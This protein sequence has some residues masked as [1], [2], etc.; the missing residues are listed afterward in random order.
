MTS[1]SSNSKQSVNIIK[2]I[3]HTR[4]YLM[5][6]EISKTWVHNTQ[7]QEIYDDIKKVNMKH[8]MYIDQI[9]D[10]LV[11]LKN[12]N[13]IKVKDEYFWMQLL[14]YDTKNNVVEMLKIKMYLVANPNHTNDTNEIIVREGHRRRYKLT[15]M[16]N[17][18][19]ENNLHMQKI[20]KK[21]IF[22][23]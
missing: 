11:D 12:F 17:F 5:C 15:F 8:D 6:C 22:D 4:D 13:I 1:T 9:I 19:M 21:I 2:S 7:Y 18:K 3:K 20:N 16:P 23:S 10:A 14:N